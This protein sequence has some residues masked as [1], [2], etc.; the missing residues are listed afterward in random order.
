MSPAAAVK[1][2]ISTV[3]TSTPP[4]QVC[5]EPSPMRKLN[6]LGWGEANTA[7]PGGG[8]GGGVQAA[9]LTPTASAL[10]LRLVLPKKRRFEFVPQG[11]PTVPMPPQTCTCSPAIMVLDKPSG[12]AATRDTLIGLVGKTPPLALPWTWAL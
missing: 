7:R 8:M 9:V 11:F 3:L 4:E 6:V 2:G 1:A 5:T 10:G 12:M